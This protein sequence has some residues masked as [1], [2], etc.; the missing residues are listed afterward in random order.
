MRCAR[1]AS[2][3]RPRLLTLEVGAGQV[4]E[5]H[6][7]LRAE[8]VAP[9]GAQMGE[10]RVLVFEQSI[11][12]A[13]ERVVLGEAFVGT[14]Q[15]GTGGGG[16]P[17][18]VQP[19]FAPGRKQAIE[20]EQAQDFL[21]VGAFAAAAQARGEEGVQVK[22]APEL[23]AQP[24]RAPGTGTAEPELGELPLHGGRVGGGR[25]A[26][27]GEKRALAGPAVVLVKDV[28]GL[29]PGGALGVVDLAQIEDVTLHDAAPQAAALD[30]GPGAMLFAVLLALAAL[31]KHGAIVTPI[32]AGG[33]GQVA[34]THAWRTGIT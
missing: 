31:E 21:P 2:G 20:R 30:D 25:R 24:A 16:K 19:P 3:C 22:F 33:R 5:Q 6:L 27:V 7:E 11:Q 10:E 14:E 15:V 18:P 23:I 8:Q 4:V 13:I 34:T 17:V 32:G 9:A 12:A 1:S 29:L 28:D 26:V